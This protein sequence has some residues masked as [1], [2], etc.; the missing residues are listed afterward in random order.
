MT[1]SSY[2]EQVQ[3]LQTQQQSLALAV[4]KHD[5]SVRGMKAELSRSSQNLNAC[6][7]IIEK[8]DEFQRKSE[9]F[10]VESQA[11]LNELYYVQTV[12]D[13]TREKLRI[14]SKELHEC[15]YEESR[16]GIAERLRDVLATIQS[17]PQKVK[18]ASMIHVKNATRMLTEI[19]EQTEE[20][21]HIAK[22]SVQA[23]S[24]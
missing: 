6:S 10:R 20:V 12:L 24:G 23:Y 1:N 3:D 4:S 13:K 21:L 22:W 18:S 8:V 16:R 5:A 14:I 7:E 9:T 11:S 19:D 2:N 15:R 17:V